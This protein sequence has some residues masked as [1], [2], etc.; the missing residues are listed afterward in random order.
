MLCIGQ[1]A[2][3]T[4]NLPTI[5]LHIIFVHFHPPEFRTI[6]EHSYHCNIRIFEEIRNVTGLAYILHT[7]WLCVARTYVEVAGGERAAASSIRRCIRALHALPSKNE[8]ACSADLRS[9]RAQHDAVGSTRSSM[10][11]QPG[12]QPGMLLSF[13]STLFLN[14]YIFKI[15]LS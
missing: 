2:N 12:R 5:H 1:A 4:T 13:N 9:M 14:K 8:R 11:G 6:S 7:Y 3:S 15:I 10:L